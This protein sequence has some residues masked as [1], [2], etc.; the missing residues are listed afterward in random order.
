[1][2]LPLV[3]PGVILGI[4]I[5][6]LASSVANGLEDSYNLELD[7]LRPGIVLVVLGQISFTTT[8]TTLVIS[9]RLKKFDIAMEGGGFEFGGLVGEEYCARVTLPFLRTRHDRFRYRRLSSILSRISI[10]HCF[11]LVPK[12]L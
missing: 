4:S 8:I 9:A 2:I 3:I 12:P 10:Q 7:F 11:L 5:L 6:V 1:M